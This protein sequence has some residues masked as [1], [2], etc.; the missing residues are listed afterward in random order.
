VFV[1]RCSNNGLKRVNTDLPRLDN[2]MDKP[3]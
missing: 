3:L 1:I 2:S